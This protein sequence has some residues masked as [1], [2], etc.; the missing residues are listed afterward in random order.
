M[1]AFALRDLNDDQSQSRVQV[2]GGYADV[3]GRPNTREVHV[4]GTWAP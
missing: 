4:I 2:I 1:R 3:I